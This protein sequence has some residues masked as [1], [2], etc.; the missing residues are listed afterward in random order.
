MPGNK[1][2]RIAA[3]ALAII[4]V[5]GCTPSQPIR[6]FALTPLSNQVPVA[7]TEQSI[8][9]FPIALANYLDRNGIVTRTSPNELTVAST[10]SWIEPLDLQIRGVVARN[11]AQLLGTDQVF[12]L[13]EQRLL[14]LDYTVEIAVER[15]DIE[16]GADDTEAA[17]ELVVFEGRW[18]LFER[19][20]RDVL[21]TAPFRI[22]EP[23]TAPATFE[24]RT[25][26]MSDAAARLSRIISTAIASQGSS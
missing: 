1:Q 19:E 17:A 5:A 15:F 21:Q 12:V 26:A 23:V 14:P 25:A 20:S 9:V 4:V 6:Y 10:D 11:V 24:S 13:P 8:G 2:S 22:T 16:L 3:I 18:S 7:K